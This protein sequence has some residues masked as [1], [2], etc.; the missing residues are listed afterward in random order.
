MLPSYSQWL[1][2]DRKLVR[3][4]E[5]CHIDG[6]KKSVHPGSSNKRTDID[7]NLVKEMT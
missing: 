7:Q 2:N 4:M 6:G 3:L 1:V 5:L